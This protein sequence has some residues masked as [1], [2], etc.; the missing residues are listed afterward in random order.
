MHSFK[1]ESE[2]DCNFDDGDMCN[3]KNA[4]TEYDTDYEWTVA[5]GPALSQGTGPAEGKGIQ[6]LTGITTCSKH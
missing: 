1:L 6:K 5:S 4:D 2:L 3:W